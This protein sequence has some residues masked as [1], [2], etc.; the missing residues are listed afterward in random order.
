MT[1]S[2]GVKPESSTVALIRSMSGSAPG[3]IKMVAFFI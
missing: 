3:A 1:A 2:P